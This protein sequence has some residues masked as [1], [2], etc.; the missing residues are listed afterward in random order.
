MAKM[1]TVSFY[2][3]EIHWEHFAAKFG[4]Q[5]ED[6]FPRE[7]DFVLQRGLMEYVG[8]YLRLT[9]HGAEHFNGIVALFYAGAV[10]QHLPQSVQRRHH[11]Q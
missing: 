5:L 4:V 1:I 8:P 3:G 7:V 6:H 11:Q 10:N 2:F 9:P